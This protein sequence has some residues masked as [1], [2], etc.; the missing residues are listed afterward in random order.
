MTLHVI[1]GIVHNDIAI[2]A[3]VIVVADA[4]VDSG[5]VG[6]NV[7]PTAIARVE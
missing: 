1:G 3:R 7:F 4:A 5:L 2:C 6:W